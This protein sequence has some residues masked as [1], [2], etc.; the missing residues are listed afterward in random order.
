MNLSIDELETIKKK[1]F[2][3]GYKKGREIGF[4]NGYAQG[5]D[6]SDSCLAARIEELEEELG[7][8]QKGGAE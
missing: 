7:K 1:S 8:Y 5:M 3:D 4:E 6:Y 2:Q